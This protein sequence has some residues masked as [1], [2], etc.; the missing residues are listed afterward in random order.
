MPS[1]QR[2]GLA[3]AVPV[4]AVVLV[5]HVLLTSEVVRAGQRWFGGAAI[6]LLVA[7]AVVAHVASF[8]RLA[9]RRGR[10]SP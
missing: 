4:I 1:R 3:V 8:R 5:G 6:G 7:A 2:R 10:R 9:A